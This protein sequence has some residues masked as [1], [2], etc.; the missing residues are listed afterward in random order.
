MT[1]GGFLS[2]KKLNKFLSLLVILSVVSSLFLPNI[3]YAVEGA[4]HEG[5]DSDYYYDEDGNLQFQIV[6]DTTEFIPEEIWDVNELDYEDDYF[7]DE[8]LESFETEVVEIDE[9]SVEYINSDSTLIEEAYFDK[10]P[11]FTTMF[12][13]FLLPAAT[14][15]VIRSGGKLLVRQYLTST[16]RNITIRNAAL[17]GKRHPTTGVLFNSQGFPQ[18]TSR[19]SFPLS[20]TYLKSSNA[21][22]FAQANR[23]LLNAVNQRS[24]TVRSRFTQSQLNDIRAGRTP[25]G[26]VWHHHQ[27]RGLLQLVPRAQHQG[28]GHTGGRAIWGTK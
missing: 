4:I 19:Y 1:N 21:T 6:E 28:T 7:Q 26:Y 2:L 13:P 16:T 18:F 10:E 17:A 20:N 22:Q 12:L 14:A 24:T 5:S 25:S 11:E 15:I 23:S 27:N 9:Q 3:S 8:Y